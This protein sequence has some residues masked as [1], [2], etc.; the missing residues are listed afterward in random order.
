MIDP[1]TPIEIELGIEHVDPKHSPGE[2]LRY[3]M[4]WDDRA[5]AIAQ[6]VRAEMVKHGEASPEQDYPQQ[7][8]EPE[9]G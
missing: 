1:R 8:Q 5:L 3:G 6:Q 4:I 7:G 9:E 2:Q